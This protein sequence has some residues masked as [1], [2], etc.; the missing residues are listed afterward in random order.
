MFPYCLFGICFVKYPKRDTK[1][2]FLSIYIGVSPLRVRDVKFFVRDKNFWSEIS[3]K[4]YK[5]EQLIQKFLFFYE[6]ILT[7]QYFN[8]KAAN[9]S[10]MA[11]I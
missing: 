2:L 3:K 1:N 9:M 8:C 6:I 7:C 11:S 5:K 10:N 4:T